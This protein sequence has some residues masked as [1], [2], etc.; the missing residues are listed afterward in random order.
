MSTAT[1]TAPRTMRTFLVIWL[2]QIIS[3]IG[4]GLTGFALAVWIFQETG[5]ATPFALTILFSNLPRILLSPFAGALVDRWNRRRIMILADAGSGIVTLGVLALLSGGRL[6]VWHI[7]LTAALYSVF[8]AFQEPAY[9]ASV[10]MLVP[11]KDLAR[12][13]GLIQMGQS[14]EALVAPLLAGVLYGLIGFRGIVLIDAMTFLFAVGALLLVHIPQPKRSE[15]VAGGESQRAGDGAASSLWRDMAFGWHY[16]RARVGLFG[17]L[18]YFALVNF[19]LNFAAVLLGPMVLSF[20]TT[21][22]LGVVQTAGGVGMLVG[23]IAISG[24]GG[25]KRRIPAVIGFIALASF[26]FFL[27]GVKSAVWIVGLGLFIAMFSVPF[28]SVL[29]QTVFQMKVAADVQGRVFAIR[30][31]ISRSMMPLAFLLA[32]PLADRLFGPLLREGGALAGSSLGALVGIGPGRG[33][34]LLFMVSGLILI[35]A[36]VVAFAHPRIRNL[37]GEL[38]NALPEAEEEGTETRAAV[39]VPA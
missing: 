38:P 5:E 28:A 36:S 8:S 32:G 24:W 6:E 21:S 7:Y 27:I 1:T 13:G 11:Q 20:S 3:I 18:L 9:A 22:A 26:G 25:P 35:G 31:M 30:G 39:S 4:S 15:G 16:L 19:F 23:S 2:G 14:L 10:T 29:S 33:I 12:A 37:E 34:G 17:L